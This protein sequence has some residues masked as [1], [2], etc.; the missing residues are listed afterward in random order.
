MKTFIRTRQDL[1]I[2]FF[3]KSRPICALSAAELGLFI[4]G[5]PKTYA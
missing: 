5:Y 3:P 2:D 4:V 1:F